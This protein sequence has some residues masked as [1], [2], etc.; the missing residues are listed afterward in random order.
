MQ[1]Q[2]FL[3]FIFYFNHRKHLKKATVQYMESHNFLW[4]TRTRNIY[5]YYTQ[6][7]YNWYYWIT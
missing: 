4:H 2:Y 7:I 5:W 3:L 6:K 1:L